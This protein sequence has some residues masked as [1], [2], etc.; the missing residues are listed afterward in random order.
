MLPRSLVFSAFLVLSLDLAAGVCIAGTDE[1]APHPSGGGSATLEP[2]PPLAARRTHRLVFACREGNLAV[3]S[4]RPCGEAAVL[5]SLEVS[6]PAASG[7]P[8]TTEPV[9]ARAATR[10]APLRDTQ[11][12]QLEQA[13]ERCERLQQD[14]E[15][16]DDRMRAG[17]PARE[18]ARLWQRWRDAKERLRAAKC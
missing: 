9:P 16:I 6:Q 5:R 17:Y 12:R 3:F 11:A 2:P 14:V 8:P 7:R 18:A 4:D 1:T 15:Q 10:P 13:A